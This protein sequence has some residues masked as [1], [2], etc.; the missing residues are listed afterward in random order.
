MTE[1]P[2]RTPSGVAME[3]MFS[4]ARDLTSHE[5]AFLLAFHRITGRTNRAKHVAAEMFG[6]T[7]GAAQAAIWRAVQEEKIDLHRALLAFDD[8]DG[9]TQAAR[10]LSVI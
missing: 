9:L 5:T 3:L 8:V 1:G 2:I 4:T 7:S 6:K 10:R